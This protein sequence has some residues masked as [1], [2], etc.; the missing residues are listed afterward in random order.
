MQ[1]AKDPDARALLKSLH[2]ESDPV[3]QMLTLLPLRRLVLAGQDTPENLELL[4]WPHYKLGAK[5]D[6]ED[7]RIECL[8]DPPP[9]PR[10]PS[11]SYSG[12]PTRGFSRK[13][14]FQPFS[15]TTRP[16]WLSDRGSRPSSSSSSNSTTPTSSSRRLGRNNRQ[17]ALT[18]TIHHR[19]WRKMP[20]VPVKRSMKQ[21][22]PT[23]SSS[24]K[25]ATG[26]ERRR[27]PVQ[28]LYSPVEVNNDKHRLRRR[29]RRRQARCSAQHS[30]PIQGNNETKYQAYVLF[31]VLKG[32]RN[33]VHGLLS[34][35]NAGFK[36]VI[37]AQGPNP[38][39]NAPVPDRLHR[40]GLGDS[41]LAAT[42]RPT[43][44]RVAAIME[45]APGKFGAR[46]MIDSRIIDIN[47]NFNPIFFRID[48]ESSWTR[49]PGR[50]R[51][52]EGL[53][54]AAAGTREASP[55][56]ASPASSADGNPGAIN[57]KSILVYATDEALEQE[58]TPPPDALKTFVKAS[59]SGEPES[60]DDVGL[61]ARRDASR[62]PAGSR[63]R[64]TSLVRAHAYAR[65]SRACVAWARGPSAMEGAWP[66]PPP[67]VP[68]RAA[69]LSDRGS[70]PGSS[71]SNSNSN[72]ST[73]PTSSSRRLGKAEPLDL[74]AAFSEIQKHETTYACIFDTVD[75]D[76]V[77]PAPQEDTEAFS[78]APDSGYVEFIPKSA[79]F[80]RGEMANTTSDVDSTG[81]SN[82]VTKSVE[83]EQD[84][85]DV[86][87]SDSGD[88]R[89][90]P[91]P[92]E[93]AEE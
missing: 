34:Q 9:C 71:S 90:A 16:N 36:Q 12:T 10:Q 72:S 73:T 1:P 42:D 50:A 19:S 51:S 67:S 55:R 78:N 66:P 18:V 11:T 75:G 64:Y 24:A 23:L 87:M 6:H 68:S 83:G 93:P 77:K 29:R 58:S 54:Q 70:R 62:V 7:M 63:P 4:F 85:I 65:G 40:L 48:N 56:A 39:V 15:R 8:L 47:F 26:D 91:A 46:S 92:A 17:L 82:M 32:A 38:D 57:S 21:H 5:K 88:T 35:C 59:R 2:L 45:R 84:I 76:D 41:G 33:E 52:A 27:R 49:C 61:A 13:A 28:Q 60:A 14:R 74:I 79:L 30:G 89:K 80:F 3:D 69:W 25:S 31:K 53:E 43:Q 20:I 37:E 86:T 81:D 44:L 22:P